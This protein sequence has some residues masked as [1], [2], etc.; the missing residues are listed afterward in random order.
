MQVI[1]IYPQ[2]FAS[3][4]F[5][6]TADNSNCILIDCAQERVLDECK[7]RNLTPRAVLLTHGHYDHIGGCAALQNEGAKIY[8]GKGEEERILSSENRDIFG[9]EIPEFTID[10]T[11]ADGDETEICGLNIKVISTAGHTSG[12][13]CYLIGDCIFSGDTLFQGSVGRSDFPTGDF[14]ALTSSVKKLY[15]LQG[16][17]KVY[18]G[19]GEPTTLEYERKFN[20]FVR[21]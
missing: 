5:I 1:T 15:A 12:G 20:P 11:F 17:Y 19:H 9:V 6:V 7:K 18:C 8:C 14:R 16:D 4:S 21:G 13:V 2:G 3:N 10:G